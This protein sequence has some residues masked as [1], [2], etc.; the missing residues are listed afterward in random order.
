MVVPDCPLRSDI[1]ISQVRREMGGIAVLGRTKTAAAGLAQRDPVARQEINAIRT[2]KRR[3]VIDAN[4]S[5]GAGRASIHARSRLVK[6]PTRQR[7]V[8]RRSRAGFEHRF[9]A[10]PAPKPAW[11]ARIRDQRPATHKH[12][13]LVFEQLNRS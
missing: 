4:F 1:A 9:L 5:Q 12:W 3:F 2:G 13:R 7:G 6:A 11:A 10:K 8:N